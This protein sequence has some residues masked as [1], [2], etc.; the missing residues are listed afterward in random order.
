MRGVKKMTELKTSVSTPS[1]NRGVENTTN[2]I[3]T[4]YLFDFEPVLPQYIIFDWIQATIFDLNGFSERDY[5]YLIF[6][7]KP[8]FII[9]ENGGLFGYEFTYSYKNIKLFS[10]T[11]KD[12]GFHFYITGSGCRNIE[13]LEL[14]YIN[15][16][17]RLL[18]YNSKFTRL[19]ISIDDFTNDY[20]TVKK[21]KN[22]IDKKLVRSKFK[23]TVQFIKNGLSND[24]L[25]G[26]TIWFGSRS[27]SIQVCIYDKKQERENNNYFLNDN[28]KY[29]TRT[30]IRF[31]NLFAQDVINNLVLNNY[32]LN[33]LVKGVLL[34]YI[35]FL[36]PSKTDSNKSRWLVAKWWLDFCDNV[37]RLKL[38]SLP[39]E[40]SISKKHS[41]LSQFVSKSEFSVFISNLP[42]LNVDYITSDFI[43]N[44][45]YTGFDKITDNDLQYINEY[46]I[47]RGF[48]PL[49]ISDLSD[50][51]RSVKDVLLIKEK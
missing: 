15:I 41:W 31:R 11:N 24:K 40:T 5:F 7:I 46:R 2:I 13:E 8:D 18:H 49:T 44:Q 35:Q 17:N 22:Y 34:N 42:D 28:I 16:F 14:D 47:S 20:F 39:Y 37:N 23:T 25:N 1:T 6:G 33:D 19:D 3:Q 27:S 45:L 4:Q 51:V 26:N 48:L 30:E 36:I 10:S 32:S 38:H 29:W 9:F 50:F 43:Y 21:I 12:L